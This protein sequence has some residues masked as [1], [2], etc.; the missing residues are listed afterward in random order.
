MKG[1]ARRGDCHRAPRQAGDVDAYAGAT[2]PRL[3]MTP[4]AMFNIASM[5]KP[6]TAVAALKLVRAGQTA[7]RRSAGKIFSEIRRHARGGAGCR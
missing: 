4:D 7:D 1:N 2:R 5:T 6:M 3:A